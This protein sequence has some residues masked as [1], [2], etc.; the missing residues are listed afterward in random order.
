MSISQLSTELLQKVYGYA[1]IQDVINLSMTSKRNWNVFMGRKLPILQQAFYNSPYSPYPE[2]IKLVISGLPDTNRKL[3]GTE[4]RRRSILNHCISVGIMRNL[5]L[6][7]IKKMVHYA[8][9]ADRWTELYPQL[10]WRFD[11][12]ERRILRPHEAERL[13]RA[14]YQY[15]TYCNLFQD[16]DYCEWDPEP[17]RAGPHY[18]NDLRLRLARTWTTIEIVRQSEFVDKMRQL[19]EIDLCPS[20]AM[21]QHRFSRSFPQKQLAKYAWGDEEEYGRLGDAL[22]KLNPAEFLHLYQNT[23]TKSERLD[24]FKTKGRWFDTPSSWDVTVQIMAADERRRPHPHFPASTCSAIFPYV[25]LEDKDVP[26]GIIDCSEKD[27]PDYF[28]T[29][30]YAN[31]ASPS[32]EWIDEYSRPTFQSPLW[33]LEDSDDSDDVDAD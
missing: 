5:S 19:V 16:Q 26:F 4:T 24:Y 15:W 12:D 18:R 17:P 2:L 29:H 20:N 30:V 6:D 21:I 28:K 1:T 10:R 31:D 3:V 14:I 25:D 32:G 11:S 7:F 22:L 23:T 9:V 13:R 27:G 33:M 8:K